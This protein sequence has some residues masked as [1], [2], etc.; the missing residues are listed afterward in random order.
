M[1]HHCP[2][3]VLDDFLPVDDLELIRTFAE[4]ASGAMVASKIFNA[5]VP[6]GALD[7]AYRRSQ[8]APDLEEIWGLL[9]ERLRGLLP[10]V[11]SELGIPHFELGW[12]ERQMT[13][14][15]DGDFFKRHTDEHHPLTDG[16]R[17]LTFVYYFQRDDV[18]FQGGHLRLYAQ[19]DGAHGREQ[20]DEYVEIAPGPNSIVF[21]PAD[22]QHEVTLVDGGGADVERWTVNG[23]FRAGDLGRPRI[24]TVTST[25]RTALANR[26]V[27]VV[28]DCWGVR[29]TPI[30]VHRLLRARWTLDRD[31]QIDEVDDGIS[32][33][34]T[35]RLLPIE[36]IASDVLEALRPLH[37]EWAGCALTPTAAY[38]LRTFG[39]GQGI[40]LHVERVATH[41]VSSVIVVDLDVD[42]PYMMTLAEAGRTHRLALGAGQMI[43]Y[44]G[45]R[46]PHGHLEPLRGR[47][48]TVLM[49]HYAPHDW[50]LD[51]DELVRRAVAAGL[52]D[53][54]GALTTRFLLTPHP[55]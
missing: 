49:L 41:V 10:I 27:P 51:E 6:D 30:A 47:S 37:E 9:D 28:A 44:E 39:P 17:V 3:I 16:A 23:W 14:S 2:H 4:K 21:F 43:L 48:A 53:A 18:S 15:R 8:V 31:A 19:R 38:G 7:E 32:I 42:E 35:R 55:T 36:P 40:D 12:V 1:I 25:V 26:I 45:A 54:N 34:G 20:A 52:V 22:W 46:V 24:P 33:G 5:T 29:P 11:R 50:K 13:V